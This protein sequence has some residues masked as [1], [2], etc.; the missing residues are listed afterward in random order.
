MCDQLLYS[1]LHAGHVKGRPCFWSGKP[2]NIKH[3]RIDHTQENNGMETYP[4]CYME[5]FYMVWIF[6]YLSHNMFV[7]NT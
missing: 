3:I 7:T 6:Q 1:P 2:M 4:N 5:L